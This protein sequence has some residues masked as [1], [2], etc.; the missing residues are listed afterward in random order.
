MTL[1]VIVRD[2][3]KKAPMAVGSNVN[4]RTELPTSASRDNGRVLRAGT[5]DLQADKTAR[6]PGSVTTH[7]YPAFSMH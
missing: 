3:T 5:I 1:C 2:D 4:R 6:K 7:G